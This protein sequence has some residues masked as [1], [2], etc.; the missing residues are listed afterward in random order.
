[1]THMHIVWNKSLYMPVL[2]PF[3]IFP[4]FNMCSAP[5]QTN[6]FWKFQ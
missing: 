5:N 1:M 6:L 2:S 3:L 4:I